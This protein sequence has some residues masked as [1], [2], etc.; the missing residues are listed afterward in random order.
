MRISDLSHVKNLIGIATGQPSRARRAELLKHAFF[1]AVWV[2]RQ[3]RD[4]EMLPED[5]AR[6]ESFNDGLDL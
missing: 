6:L 5:R 4:A 2:Q 1:G 3:I